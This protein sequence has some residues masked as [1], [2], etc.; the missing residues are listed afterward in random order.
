VLVGRNRRARGFNGASLRMK[1]HKA[2]SWSTYPGSAARQFNDWQV[3]SEAVGHIELAAVRV[4]RHV[5]G[6]LADKGREV[7]NLA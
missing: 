1:M 4:E 3:V 5:P 6:T 7:H 2:C